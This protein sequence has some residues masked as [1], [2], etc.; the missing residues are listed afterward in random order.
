MNYNPDVITIAIAE[1]HNLVRNGLI[2]MINSFPSIAVVADAGNGKELIEKIKS[3]TK[4]PDICILDI[5]MP[6]LNGYD[7]LTKLKRAYMHM[8][9]IVLTMFKN[10]YNII[11]MIKSGANAYLNKNTTS[12]ELLKAI[13][14]VYANDYYYSAIASEKT[15]NTI[16]NNKLQLLTER[17]VQFLGLNCGHYSYIEIAEKMCLSVRTVQDYQKNLCKKLH[18]HT[19]LDLALFA[20][21]SGL[22]PLK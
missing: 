2:D 20:M 16:K 3:L 12:V 15:F 6:E 11:R 10:E 17:E 13:K 19:R 14:E 5:S 4:E 7:T 9:F 1:D 21:Q 22:V 8:K 18:L